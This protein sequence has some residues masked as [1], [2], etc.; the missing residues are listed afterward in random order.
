M[1]IHSQRDPQDLI[2]KTVVYCGNTRASLLGG[3]ELEVIDARA[4]GRAVA[5]QGPK[6]VEWI[7]INSVEILQPTVTDV[8]ISNN[9]IDNFLNP[10]SRTIAA[11]DSEISR[12]QDRINEL[13]A[14]RQTISAL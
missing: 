4:D 5:V 11:L 6:G 14:A 7:G 13:R 1:N 12:L 3:K 2:G 10:H 8:K 9:D